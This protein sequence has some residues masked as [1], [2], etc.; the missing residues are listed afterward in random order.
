MQIRSIDE[1]FQE[2][3]NE[4]QNLSNLD[5]LDPNTIADEQTL[6]NQMDSGYSPEWVLW[7]YNQAV[8]IHLTE[9]S[10][11]T[12]VNEINNALQEKVTPTAQW[13]VE[14]VLKFQ[15]GDTLII[16]SETYKP[17]YS[18]INET[19]QIIE[20][21]TTLETQNRL[22][23]KVKRTGGSLLSSDEKDS[24]QSYINSIK[25]AGTQIVIENYNPD[26]VTINAT[27][28]YKSS[29][30]KNQVQSNI[31]SVINDYLNNI[32]FDSKF[33]TSDLEKRIFNE[34]DNVRDFRFDESTVVN[35]LNTTTNFLH[36]VQ[37]LAGHGVID[38]NN[39]LSDTITYIA[40]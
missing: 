19:N 1:I 28:I 34:V 40:K 24:L 3:L 38:S 14:Q 33:I 27:I 6:I 10:I 25:A 39:P 35:D 21:A 7:L 4:K 2:L 16:D 9:Y 26:Q 15:Y 20:S 13:Y 30:D 36:E 29:A 5:S 8:Q 11:Q 22:N 37:F 23:I 31:E 32:R 12:A 17:K 18:T